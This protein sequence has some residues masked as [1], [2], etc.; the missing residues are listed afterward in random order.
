MVHVL[1]VCKERSD[2]GAFSSIVYI[3]ATCM[4]LELIEQR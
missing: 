4:S 2:S 1:A 3:F